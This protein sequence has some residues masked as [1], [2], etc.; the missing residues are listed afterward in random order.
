MV[1]TKSDGANVPTWT[2]FAVGEEV[3]LSVRAN[4]SNWS[5]VE[6]AVGGKLLIDNGAVTTSGIDGASSNRARSAIGVKSDGTVVLYEIDGNQASSAGL[7]A[8][9]LGQELLDS[10][11][12]ARSAWTAAAPLPWRCAS[13]VKARLR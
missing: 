11:A 12:S 4:D 10:A 2:D 1:L 3:T 9:Q 5:E 7:T 13:L 6:Y 8:A